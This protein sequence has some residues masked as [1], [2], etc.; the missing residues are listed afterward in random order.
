MNKH[1]EAIET[2]LSSQPLP[3]PPRG[4]GSPAK[5]LCPRIDPDRVAVRL[6]RCVT[7]ASVSLVA[8]FASASTL[9]ADWPLVR[10]DAA[11][12]GAVVAPL[13][14]PLDILWTYEAAE[15]GFEA[16]ASIVEGVVYVGDVDGTFHA[17][18]L[19][20]GSPLWTRK[21]EETGFVAGSAVVEGRIYCVDYNGVVRCLKIENGET[22]WEFNTDTSLYAAPNVYE[23]VVLLAA[24]S[25]QLFAL[26]AATGKKKWE[27]FTIDQP[28][29]CWPTVVAERVLIA[30]CDGKL[31]L[32]DV[33]TGKDVESIDI[34]GPAD[35][36]PA[37]VGDRVFFCTAG[38]VFHG[39]T[40]KPLASLWEFGH[41]AQGEEIHAA[42]ATPNAIVLGT[43]DKRMVALKPAT[44]EVFWS[45]PLRSRAESSPVV[46]GDL[47]LF[48]TVRGRLQALEMAGGKEVWNTEVGGRFTASPALTDGRMV[49]GNE[50]GTL[51]CVGGK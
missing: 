15:S 39:M 22:I 17:V 18:K 51:Y 26:D 40:I 5:R 47:V 37:V 29:R 20:D 35:G 25:G 3:G 34:G 14:Q 46:A 16:T 23:G 28:L 36:M 32:V 44:G 42:A 6:W 27:P 2:S 48:G 19:A 45:T 21:F 43:H 4:P 12:T 24:D 31:H 7:L 49:I 38:G 8:M 30:G 1:S 33:N 50:D 13:P 41:R 9:R 10:G 11:A